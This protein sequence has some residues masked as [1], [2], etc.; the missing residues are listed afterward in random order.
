LREQGPEDEDRS[1]VR[2]VAEL[3][4]VRILLL[5]GEE[6]AELGEEFPEEVLSSEVGDDALLDL[7]GL[8][9]GLDDADLLVDDAAGGADFDGSGVHAS[10]YHDESHGL[11]GFS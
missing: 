7:T 3:G 8:A 11:Q 2:G 10:H 9:V 1:P 5:P 4:I 6:A